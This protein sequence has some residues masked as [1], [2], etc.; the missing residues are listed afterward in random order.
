MSAG[1]AGNTT[2]VVVGVLIKGDLIVAVSAAED[3]AAAPAVM[4]SG[5]RVEGLFA[6][7]VITDKCVLVQLPMFPGGGAS[8]IGK[9]VQIPSSIDV[10]GAI[11]SRPS[12]QTQ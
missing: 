9:E 8:R 11:A 10:F 5:E 3:V 4:S 6:G 12:G 1:A 7:R 2:R